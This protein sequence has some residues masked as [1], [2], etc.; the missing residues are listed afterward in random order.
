MSFDWMLPREKSIF[1]GSYFSLCTKNQVKDSLSQENKV[2]N[3]NKV[4]ATKMEIRGSYKR[5]MSGEKNSR[6]NWANHVQ[7]SQ[8]GIVYSHVCVCTQA[9]QVWAISL[10]FSIVWK[11]SLVLT[12]SCREITFLWQKEKISLHV[13]RSQ[14]I[15]VGTLDFFV[16]GY[17]PH[18]WCLDVP[19]CAPQMWVLNLI[20]Q[21]KTN[22]FLDISIKVHLERM[23][24]KWLTKVTLM[25]STCS[26]GVS[27]QHID[28]NNQ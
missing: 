20:K 18:C 2:V 23:F 3:W 14:N 25:L 8:V 15:L 24:L 19:I 4:L 22:C 12:S 27:K 28:Q 13:V 9:F 21:N 11:F 10:L 6:R 5:C 17:L 7:K 1:R 26:L 16:E